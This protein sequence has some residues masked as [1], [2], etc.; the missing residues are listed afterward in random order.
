MLY[1]RKDLFLWILNCSGKIEQ[2][3]LNSCSAASLV[4]EI[5]TFNHTI[6]SLFIIS[7]ELLKT[8]KK[9]IKKIEDS[10]I[11]EYAE[12]L[13][14]QTLVNLNEAYFHLKSLLGSTK[15]NEKEERQIISIWGKSI[16]ELCLLLD[17]KDIAAPSE[18]V[19]KTNY[20][21]SSFFSLVNVLF[22]PRNEENK[23][24]K[25]EMYAKG[26]DLKDL[27]HITDEFLIVRRID[28]KEPVFNE[29]M[30]KRITFNIGN[31]ISRVDF[32]LGPHQMYIKTAMRGQDRYFLICDP[33]I[34]GIQEFTIA[35]M[36]DFV[37][38]NTVNFE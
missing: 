34:V 11:Q 21:V 32:V 35:D 19:I 33:L 30:W 16:E 37:K 3:Y 4:N 12:K 1:N 38:K 14:D 17:P 23:P 25:L 31:P 8:V 27:I 24:P 18:N 29:E 5:L 7:K 13:S 2:A 22:S 10:K 28:D 20:H 15:Y 36:K 6:T 9:E 26:A